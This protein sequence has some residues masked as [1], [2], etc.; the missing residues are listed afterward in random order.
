[1]S[2]MDRVK[3]LMALA[4]NNPN[5]HEAAAAA[6]KAQRLMAENGIDTADFDNDMADSDNGSIGEEYSLRSGRSWRFALAASIAECFRCRCF[7]DGPSVGF[8]GAN[9]DRRI[10]KEVFEGLY[11]VGNKLGLQAVR[12]YKEFY[13]RRKHTGVYDQYVKGF[14]N[15]VRNQLTIQAKA[16]MVLIPP[17]V[18][19]QFDLIYTKEAKLRTPPSM[20][21]RARAEGVARTIFKEGYLEGKRAVSQS[22]EARYGDP[23]WDGGRQ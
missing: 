12:N 11:Y 15:G 3:K 7:I 21:H 8:Y 20:T 6:L 16:L 2:V 10:C 23:S 9:S 13:P 22:L 14:T 4:R 18:N 1:M 19:T 5:G 17:Q